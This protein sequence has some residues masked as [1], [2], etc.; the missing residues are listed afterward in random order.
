VK[1]LADADGMPQHRVAVS[2]MKSKFRIGAPSSD[3][4]EISDWQESQVPAAGIGRDHSLH[5]LARW[6]L[7]AARKGRPVADTT[8]FEGSQNRLDVGPGA[9]VGSDGR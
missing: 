6:L 1:I 3:S 2:D 4:F 5:L 7:S 9:K 8:P